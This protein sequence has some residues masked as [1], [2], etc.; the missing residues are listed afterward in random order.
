MT[1]DDRIGGGDAGPQSAEV[2]EAGN[3]GVL[4]SAISWRPRL[5]VLGAC[6]I[7]LLGLFHRT[8]LSMVDIW[9]SSE[10]YAHG[11]FVLPIS[12]ILI[13]RLRDKLRN[14]SPRTEFRALPVLAAL[15]FVWLLATVAHV[16]VV[17][18]F[19]AVAMIPTLFWLI[20]GT[21]ATAVIL[22][23]LGFLLFMV[24]VG[25]ALVSPLMDF[26][27]KFVVT[28]LDITGIPVYSDGTYITIPSGRWSVV[29]GCSGIRYLL[30]SIMLGVLFS[31]VMYRN[32]WRR[33]AFIVLAAIFPVIANGLRAYMIV[34]IAHLSDMRLAL[35]VDHY[36]YGWV[37]FGVVMFILF[38]LGSL[39]S[40]SGVEPQVLSPPR[41]DSGDKVPEPRRRL[42]NGVLSGMLIIAVWPVWAGWLRNHDGITIHSGINL[43]AAHGAWVRAAAPLTQWK[44]RYLNPTIEHRQTYTDGRREVGVYLAYY[45]AGDQDGELINIENVLVVQKHPI[46]RMPTQYLREENLVKGVDRIYESRLKSEGQ[47]LLVWHWYYLSG[48]NVTNPF[49]VKALEAFEKL[50]GSDQG[51]AALVFYAEMDEDPEP[52]RRAMRAF[53]KSM[54]SELELAIQVRR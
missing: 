9:L 33:L 40:E 7:I 8:F 16:Q 5:R 21:P 20:L 27:A 1:K 54:W 43:P 48:R 47:N 35:G 37:F 45:G 49:V 41:N 24:P 13:W 6:T 2:I 44:P 11:F 22:F 4:N 32:N 15:G 38:W 23:P 31:Y 10:T 51:C 36:I 26:T 12:A 34:M 46:W 42:L 3:S 18:Q 53:I 19:T 28:A 30:A 17:Q 50:I 29:A 52:A 39:W 25:G 14:K